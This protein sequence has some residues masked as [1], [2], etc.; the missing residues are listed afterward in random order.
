MQLTYVSILT[1]SLFSVI[2]AGP[3]PTN[4]DMSTSTF[5]HWLSS[6]RHPQSLVVIS[7]LWC[8]TKRV[9]SLDMTKVIARHCKE[10]GGDAFFST[11]RIQMLHPSLKDQVKPH[12]TYCFDLLAMSVEAMDTLNNGECWENDRS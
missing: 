3:I 7:P 6:R 11:V 12:M 10:A 1:T 9:E 8:T 4:Q 5:P 2:M